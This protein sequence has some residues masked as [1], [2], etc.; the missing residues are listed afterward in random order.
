MSALFHAV[1][2]HDVF[3][4]LFSHPIDLYKN[5]GINLQL[6]KVVA[7]NL[8]P[9]LA[10]EAPSER[11][12]SIVLRFMKFDRTRMST[13]MLTQTT[14]FKKRKIAIDIDY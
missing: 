6:E 8:L 10:G 14:F 2:D 12:F 7:Y 3:N 11:T 9:F 4:K 13:E 1:N 5:I